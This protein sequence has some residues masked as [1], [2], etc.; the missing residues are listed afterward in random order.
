MM[1][2]NQLIR[3]GVATACL[4]MVSL[5]WAQERSV[6]SAGDQV[7]VPDRGRDIDVRDGNMESSRVSGEDVEDFFS[8]MFANGRIGESGQYFDGAAQI[9][10]IRIVTDE[11]RLLLNSLDPDLLREARE[12][13]VPIV[14]T[15][16]APNQGRAHYVNA[17]SE[18]VSSLW[19]GSGA[20]SSGD[21]GDTGENTVSHTRYLNRNRYMKNQ[22][23]NPITNASH[24]AMESSMELHVNPFYGDFDQYYVFEGSVNGSTA[25]RDEYL[26]GER[27]SFSTIP[28][29]FVNA[30]GEDTK[31]LTEGV[32][33]TYF[34]GGF[35]GLQSRRTRVYKVSKLWSS[36]RY[37]QTYRVVRA[38][39]SSTPLN[40]LTSSYYIG[41]AELRG[42]RPYLTDFVGGVFRYDGNNLISN[43]RPDTSV[44]TDQSFF[45]VGIENI[46]CNKKNCTWGSGGVNQNL[47]VDATNGSSGVA[48]QLFDSRQIG[49]AFWGFGT[50]VDGS[51]KERQNVAYVRFWNHQNEVRQF[52]NSSMTVSSKDM[53]GEAFPWH[54]ARPVST[55][56]RGN[57]FCS[58]WELG[59]S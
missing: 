4:F 29:G 37:N 22:I 11:A 39:V 46:S 7:M 13:D 1:G 59:S 2:S 15:C 53:L 16:S 17:S 21:F 28:V 23:S 56:P 36:N 42:G 9:G 41:S 43:G 58:A 12:A 52:P 27:Q 20:W 51:S 35:E 24:I 55:L 32:S 38:D 5:S 47:K 50:V 48:R 45:D 49:G 54:A 31:W 10:S 18:M 26:I 40:I 6:D 30:G 3:G 34:M 8:G 25:F 33:G 44:R 14:S 19:A 57:G